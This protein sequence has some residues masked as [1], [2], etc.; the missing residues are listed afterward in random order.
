MPLLLLKSR[1][2][3]VLYTA[4][5]KNAEKQE[6]KSEEP[7]DRFDQL[8]PWYKDPGAPNLFDGHW[9]VREELA[10]AGIKPKVGLGATSGEFDQNGVSIQPR[11]A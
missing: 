7:T 5:T 6:T 8:R 2:A 1:A 10:E 4:E 11:A 3:E 9:G